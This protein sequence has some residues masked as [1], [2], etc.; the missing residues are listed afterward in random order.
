MPGA[1]A[2]SLFIVLL[3]L[4]APAHAQTRPVLTIDDSR[5]ITELTAAVSI[6]VPADVNQ[7]P[8]CLELG[9]PCSSPRTFPD[10]GLTGSLVV[11]PIDAVGI[12]GEGSMYANGWL[13]YGR[14]PFITPSTQPCANTQ[15]NHVSSALAGVR[16]R[17][18]LI[19]SGGSHWR[20]FGQA[21]GG[22]QWSDV[23]P[24]HRVFQPGVGGDNYLQNG[25]AVHVEYDYRFAP[26]DRRDLSTSRFVAGI[27]I[28]LGRR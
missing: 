5:T 14:C 2:S 10:F 23:G 22:P 1:R 20:L 6:Q 13:A 9:L 19:R 26:D 7:R 28:P 18:S 24:Q 21:L 8:A 11:Y 17:T 12:V 16:V 25:I 4:A 3:C 15:D 27:G